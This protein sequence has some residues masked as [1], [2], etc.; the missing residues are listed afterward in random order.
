MLCLPAATTAG[1]PSTAV[2][3][4]APVAATTAGLNNVVGIALAGDALYVSDLSNSRI[5]KINLTAT[6][7]TIETLVGRAGATASEGAL[8][9]VRLDRPEGLWLAG[10][11]LYVAEFGGDRIL[12]VDLSAR[13]VTWLAGSG[14]GISDGPLE[15]ALLG[16][17]TAI[18]VSPV[19]GDIFIAGV[20]FLTAAC[21]L[22]MSAARSS[23]R[24][25][26]NPS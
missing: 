18:A 12:Q 13:T 3:D 17:P 11:L 21:M 6:P 5:R 14:S 9:S 16:D 25:V 23:S 19:N 24:Q 2:N 20:G 26:A 1:T 15:T 4:T 8:S 7:P 22:C 10:S